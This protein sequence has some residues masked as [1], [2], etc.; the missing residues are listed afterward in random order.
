MRSHIDDARRVFGIAD[1]GAEIPAAVYAFI[2]ITQFNQIKA[3]VECIDK[4][5]PVQ[6][7]LPCA[8]CISG[9]QRPII[10]V[11]DIQILSV[12]GRDV[13]CILRHTVILRCA[14]ASACLVCCADLRAGDSSF[15]PN[16]QFAPARIL[17]TDCN[18]PIQRT[19][20]GR[21]HLARRRHAGICMFHIFCSCYYS[22]FTVLSFCFSF[23]ADIRNSGNRSNAIPAEP[24]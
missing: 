12:N 22:S 7:A 3:I 19:W 23:C 10:V 21:V 4:A 15:R 18:L 2:D 9:F 16:G 1:P 8:Q 17:P 24:A 20:R 11:C 13:N 14:G 5:P 6:V